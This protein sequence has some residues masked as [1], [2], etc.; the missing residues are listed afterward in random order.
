[1]L[2]ALT[3]EMHAEVARLWRDVARDELTKPVV[4]TGAGPG[5]WQGT[6]S[7]SPTAPGT[8]SPRL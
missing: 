1:V 3:Y 6:T 5:F 2:S 7:R 4:D 8:T